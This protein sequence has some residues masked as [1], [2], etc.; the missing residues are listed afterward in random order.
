M[1]DIIEF[2]ILKGNAINSSM[3]VER[4]CES[5]KVSIFSN[6]E[7]KV[8]S[9]EL[10]VLDISN[11]SKTRKEKKTVSK[12]E[13]CKK[14]YVKWGT[15]FKSSNVNQAFF[16]KLYDTLDILKVEISEKSW[17]KKNYSSPKEEAFEK[18]IAIFAGESQLNS[19]KIGYVGK[20]A[21]FFGLFQLSSDGLGAAKKWASV[22]PEVK[23][24]KNIKS[25]M[26]LSKYRN[27]SASQQLDYL[28][29]FIG[30]SR[31]ASKIS[32]KEKL[33]PAKLWSMIKLPNLNENIPS[34]KDRRN[35]SVIQQGKKNKRVFVDNKIPYGIK[36]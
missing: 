16:E 14:M 28:V 7:T 12:S 30:A 25:N 2:S 10:D 19:R 18:V 15:K 11:T 33:S 29:A 1:V 21:T 31:E 9:L 17:D 8:E 27:L 4:M 35:R 34:K 20:E 13:I 32:P 5:S 24:M 23:G 6:K 3:D 22:H 26:T 36:Q